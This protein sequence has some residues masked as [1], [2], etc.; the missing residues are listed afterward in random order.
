[1]FE[2]LLSACLADAPA[3]CRTERIPAGATPLACAPVAALA[4]AALPAGWQ[5]QGWPCVPAGETPAVAFTEIAPG[6]LVHKA[7]HAETDAANGGD[8]ANVGVVIGRDAVAVIDA[9][10]SPAVGAA[11]LDAIRART[12]LP[13][14]WLI[15]THMH[16]DH[17]LGA[18]AFAQAG[19]RV[20]GHVRLPEALAARAVHYAAANAR[21]LGG[22]PPALP[23]VDE[24]VAGTRDIDLGGRVLRLEAHPTAHT[25]ND[26]TVRDLATDTWFLGDLAFLGHAPSLDGSIRG[27]IA[28]LDDL[29][30]RPA[31]RVVPGHGPVSAPWP[32]AAQ[33]TRDYL[34]QIVDE[35]RAAIR[36]G[37]PML[38]ATREVGAGL[39]PR[40]LLFDVF[41]PR[42][43]AAAFQ[44][45]E[46]E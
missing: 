41:N 23:A 4:V 2:L 40:W 20:I 5:A 31:A 13:V 22:P 7:L 35:T 30:A 9:G 12:R 32:G 34:K 1:V 8:I 14:R 33:P 46:W 45:L 43:V 28:L 39:A 3:T 26:L 24:M 6:V 44:E 25:D 42:N 38:A 21:A 10:G 16:P 15:L 27:W 37:A 19:A 11:L 17:T 18:A 36:A 29:A